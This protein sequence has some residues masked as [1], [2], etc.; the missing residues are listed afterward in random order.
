MHGHLQNVTDDGSLFFKLKLFQ[1][2]VDVAIQN[3]T[4]MTMDFMLRYHP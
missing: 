1:L 2:P 4:S 3:V